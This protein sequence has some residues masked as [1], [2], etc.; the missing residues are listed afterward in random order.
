MPNLVIF[1]VIKS[2]HDIFTALWIGGI[3]VTLIIFLPT[4]RKTL[5]RDEKS[6]QINRA[7]Q[8][9]LRIAAVISMVGLW[10]T[11]LLLGRQSPG[12]SGLFQFSTTYSVLISVKHIFTLIMI[13]IAVWRGFLSN[14]RQMTAG[15][16]REKGRFALLLL[17]SLL[18]L[19]VL[20]LSGISAAML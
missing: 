15:S 16:T 13:L 5:G 3:W 8:N 10:I 20:F 4:L 7:Y 12:F 14:G 9:R 11:G 17:N 18:G 1:G 6:L 2:L 19:G